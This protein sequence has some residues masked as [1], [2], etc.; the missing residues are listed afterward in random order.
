MA[1][2]CSEES[3]EWCVGWIPSLVHQWVEAENVT[4][5]QDNTVPGGVNAIPPWPNQACLRKKLLIIYKAHPHSQQSCFT[6]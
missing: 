6:Y 2:C 3:P 4:V 1:G 5:L